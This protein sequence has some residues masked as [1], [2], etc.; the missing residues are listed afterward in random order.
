MEPSFVDLIYLDPPFMSGRRFGS[1]FDDRW[2]KP[3][4]SA[5]EDGESAAMPLAIGE[6]I[7]WVSRRISR[8][9]GRYLTFI[10]MR[11]VE[12][13]RI[14]KPTGSLYLHCDPT[15]GAYLRLLADAIFGPLQ[16]RN[17]IVWAY[18]SGGS[19][20]RRFARKHDTIL[21]YARDAE[22]CFF[23]VQVEKS[24]N[25]DLKPYRF[26]GVA[27]SQD[28]IGWHTLVRMR[29]VWE[30]PMVGR[31]SKERTG[32]P[33]QKPEALLARIIAASSME[34]D[35]VLDPFCGSGTTIAV[36]ARLGRRWIGIDLNPAAI[37]IAQSR[38]SAGDATRRS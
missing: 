8:S 28:E 2:N 38:L 17:E 16:F 14:L 13:H 33:T 20:A 23:Q 3:D 31:T 22:R 19:T 11:L 37:D 34:G 26:R 9:H 15:A 30:I 35:L 18:R 5:A 25:R 10:A 7:D 4:S 32:W 36:A 21:Y 24:Y 29:D 1:A 12:C 6:L 27:E